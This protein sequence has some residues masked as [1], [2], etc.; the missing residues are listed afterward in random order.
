[1]WNFCYRCDDI[2]IDQMSSFFSDMD[3][4]FINHKDSAYLTAQEK[5]DHIIINFYDKLQNKTIEIKITNNKTLPKKV[6]DSAIEPTISILEHC[7][8][9]KKYTYFYND[10]ADK[11]QVCSINND[12]VASTNSL[13]NLFQ[14]NYALIDSLSSFS[15]RNFD[16]YRNFKT[17]ST[18]NSKSDLQNIIGLLGYPHFSI[19]LSDGYMF[20]IY[21]GTHHCTTNK[22]NGFY[23][24]KINSESKICGSYKLINK[25]NCKNR[26][27]S[28][29]IEQQNS[30]F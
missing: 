25:C 16:V 14:N 13:I 3:K 26:S 28:K 1:M 6:G 19:T 11:I 27:I 30:E 15:I 9:N 24:L 4:I 8:E 22:C 18:D 12:I 20:W 21:F 7:L 17:E 29:I 5:K 10:K 2:L 23:L